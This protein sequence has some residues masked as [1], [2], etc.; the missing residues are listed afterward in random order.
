M[1]EIQLQKYKEF[2]FFSEHHT[3]TDISCLKEKPSLSLHN[4]WTVLI[5]IYLLKLSL[6]YELNAMKNKVLIIIKVV[7]KIINY[8]LESIDN[9]FKIS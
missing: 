3:S 5:V 7:Q 8:V 2:C 6:Y 4:L 9:N 1:K